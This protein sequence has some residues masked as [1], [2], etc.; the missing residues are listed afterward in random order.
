MRDRINQRLSNGAR[1]GGT[2]HLHPR[3][4]RRKRK[5]QRD[6]PRLFENGYVMEVPIRTLL[7]WRECRQLSGAWREGRDNGPGAYRWRGW[8]RQMPDASIN[9]GCTGAANRNVG[10]GPAPW[11][12]PKC[13]QY[14][15]P[16]YAICSMYCCQSPTINSVEPGNAHTANIQFL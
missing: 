13:R 14:F 15:Q 12:P 8:Q 5:C 9:R 2:S 16:A 10:A 1:V 11:H 7:V 4:Y 6:V 3:Y